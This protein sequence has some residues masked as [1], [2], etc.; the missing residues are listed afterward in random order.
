MTIL[1]PVL[2]DGNLVFVG[3]QQFPV[4]SSAIVVDTV[5]LPAGHW[6]PPYPN[7]TQVACLQVKDPLLD[8]LYLSWSLTQWQNAIKGTSGSP[9]PQV[10]TQQFNIASPSFTITS[11]T[12][13]G[14]TITQVSL[15]GI[16][17]NNTAYSFSAGV[18]TFTSQ[19]LADDVVI[20][21]YYTT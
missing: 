6:A 14:A 11:A 1:A 4:D 19:L 16:V 18:L 9:A 12:L 21:I 2:Y 7:P 10:K 8:T 15:N 20:V 5:M 3:G 13:T 17:L